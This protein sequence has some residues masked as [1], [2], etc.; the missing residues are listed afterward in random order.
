MEKK[1]RTS[2]K[3][4]FSIEGEFITTLAREWL[5]KGEYKKAVDLLMSCTESEERTEEEHAHL[6]YDILDG[7]YQIKGTYPNDDYRI[8]K[9]SKGR[10]GIETAFR[11]L[12]EKAEKLEKQYKERN[13][14]LAFLLEY[15]QEKMPYT[16]KDL[17]DEFEYQYEYPLL[18]ENSSEETVCGI[19]RNP[20]LDEFLE[21]QKSEDAEEEYGW[22]EPNGTWHCVPW[23]EHENWANDY[24]ET[25]YP[26]EKHPELYVH[27]FPH[28]GE[29]KIEGGDVLTYK[30]GWIC[31][32]NPAQGRGRPKLIAKPMTKE[33]REYLY[34]YYTKRKR[35]AEA[36]ALYEE[37][38]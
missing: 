9:D 22:L 27:T 14:Q 13:E 4:F 11:D 1:N 34:D 12:K 32:D 29:R 38:S 24:L 17:E 25:H 23:G 7:V 6:V 15:L 2:K 33:Q 5:A 26:E 18:S 8:T 30:L 3:L 36:K 21:V 19:D 10:T 16:L 20:L 37:E 35:Y 31:L 28:M